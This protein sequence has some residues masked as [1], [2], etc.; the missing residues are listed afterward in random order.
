MPP[1]KPVQVWPCMERYEPLLV[2]SGKRFR[3]RPVPHLRTSL[4][5]TCDVSSANGLAFSTETS[6]IIYYYC[7]LP[8]FNILGE[9]RIC[10][11]NF[12]CWTCC[13]YDTLRKD[14]WSLKNLIRILCLM[15]LLPTI[16]YNLSSALF[17]KSCLGNRLTRYCD[18]YC[19]L[20]PVFKVVGVKQ[21]LFSSA[22][23]A[24]VHVSGLVM[25]FVFDVKISC[26]SNMIYISYNHVI[27]ETCW[28]CDT[29]SGPVK[30]VIWHS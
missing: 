18:Q 21:T 7:V 9:K 3:K 1:F 6:C 22:T 15:M 26:R 10:I 20:W 13:T 25:F 23:S 4:I 14:T 29:C 2:L 19:V 17:L 30:G 11:S 28:S 12:L 27:R 5:V 8:L 24:L 16:L